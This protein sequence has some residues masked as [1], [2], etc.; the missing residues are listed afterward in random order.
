MKIITE[1]V[2]SAVLGVALLTGCNS[3]PVDTSKNDQ[4]GVHCEEWNKKRILANYDLNK[5]G[6][7]DLF[8]ARKFVSEVIDRDKNG[9]LS[10]DEQAKLMEADREFGETTKDSK[11][12]QKDHQTLRNLAKV[13]GI[14]ID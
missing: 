7:L 1:S 11:D 4:T 6:M 10:G 14:I 12:Y 9:T 8:E 2:A 3:K 5:D 13:G